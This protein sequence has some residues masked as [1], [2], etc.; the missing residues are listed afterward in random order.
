MRPLKVNNLIFFFALSEALTQSTAT[1]QLT[2]PD[3]TFAED[4]REGLGW[5]NVFLCWMS[6][7]STNLGGKST[8]Q[9]GYLLEMVIGFTSR[10]S[11]PDNRFETFLT[12]IEHP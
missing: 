3:F 6:L 10:A 2:A 9:I 4:C 1:L 8:I 11:L 12:F 5:A 7:L